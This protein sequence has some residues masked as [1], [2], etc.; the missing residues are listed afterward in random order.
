MVISAVDDTHISSAFNREVRGTF[1][2]IM[3][4]LIIAVF[5]NDGIN[6]ELVGWSQ[7]CVSVSEFLLHGGES[8]PSFLGTAY[9]PIDLY[10]KIVCK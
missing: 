3:A 5:F 2:A 10:I 9:E 8:F 6:D 7:D 4:E 1:F